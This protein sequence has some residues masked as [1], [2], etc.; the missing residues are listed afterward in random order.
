MA[1][2]NLNYQ[3]FENRGNFNIGIDYTGTQTDTEFSEYFAKS[4]RIRLSPFL[5]MNVAASFEVWRNFSIYGRIEN[6][7]DKSYEEALSFGGPGINGT[8]GI[9]TKANF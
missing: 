1:S 5:L 2:L 4:N 7:L 8:F 9:R 3:F 6:I